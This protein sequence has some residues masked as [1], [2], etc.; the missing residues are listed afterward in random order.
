MFF[1]ITVNSSSLKSVILA[2]ILDSVLIEF[3]SGLDELISGKRHAFIHGMRIWNTETL[4]IILQSG[5]IHTVCLRMW[6][7]SCVDQNKLH[8]TAHPGEVSNWT[9]RLVIAQ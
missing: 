3:C 8:N 2:I 6:S 1:F 4:A 5:R 9:V 7:H